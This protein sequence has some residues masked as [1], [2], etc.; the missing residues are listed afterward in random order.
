MWETPRVPDECTDAQACVR[1]RIQHKY[2][3]ALAS[4]YVGAYSKIYMGY[5]FERR[6]SSGWHLHE[7]VRNRILN[8]HGAERI[9]CGRKDKTYVLIFAA[10]RTQAKALWQGK[11]VLVE[12]NAF[13]LS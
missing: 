2:T 11:A 13:E 12:T 6:Q 7:R 8:A 1:A 5:L 4:A 10:C 3:A 9:V